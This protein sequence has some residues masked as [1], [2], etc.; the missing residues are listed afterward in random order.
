MSRTRRRDNFLHTHSGIAHS[1]LCFQLSFYALY[2]ESFIQHTSDLCLNEMN[3]CLTF[4]IPR[5][6]LRFGNLSILRG[7][8]VTST[9]FY[10]YVCVTAAMPSTSL[11]F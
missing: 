10:E 6:G 11:A 1:L 2:Y 8:H 9:R 4:V 3:P 5:C 7:H